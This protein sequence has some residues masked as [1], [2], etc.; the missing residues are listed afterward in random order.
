ME[1]IIDVHTDE[2]LTYTL[3]YQLGKGGWNR[4]DGHNWIFSL[5]NRAFVRSQIIINFSRALDVLLDDVI[6]QS[7]KNA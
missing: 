7:R 6:E 2:F 1:E 4:G 3:H 5:K